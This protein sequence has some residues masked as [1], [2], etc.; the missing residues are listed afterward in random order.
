MV[1][2][3]S[4]KN[5]GVINIETVK[6]IVQEMSKCA[7]NLESCAA[8]MVSIL[9]SQSEPNSLDLRML[10]LAFNYI[11]DMIDYNT[12]IHETSKQFEKFFLARKRNSRS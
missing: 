8:E 9:R 6:I 12:I 1:K 5:L 7:E 4:F 2:E 10:G 3:S 11:N